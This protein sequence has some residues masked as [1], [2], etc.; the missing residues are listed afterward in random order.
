MII[1]KIILIII[2]I[3]IIHIYIYIYVCVEREREIYIYIYIYT[4]YLFLP[5]GS[6]VLIGSRVRLRRAAVTRRDESPR[7]PDSLGRP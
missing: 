1:M 5:H 2:I 6:A 4:Q 7:P 3:I